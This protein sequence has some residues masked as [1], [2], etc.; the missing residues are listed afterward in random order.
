MPSTRQIDGL[1]AIHDDAYVVIRASEDWAD[2]YRQ[3]PKQFKALIRSENRQYRN[4]RQYF[5]QLANKRI[6]QWINASEYQNQIVKRGMVEAAEITVTITEQSNDYKAEETL[7]L[8]VMVDEVKE[9]MLQGVFGAREVYTRYINTAMV[10][11]MI[12]QQAVDHAAA[13]AKGLTTTTL[14]DVQRS[15]ATSINNGEDLAHAVARLQTIISNPARAELIAR[16][17]SVRSYQAGKHQYAIQTKAATK[18]WIA[19]P[20]ADEGSNE[21]PCVDDAGQAPIALGNNFISGDPYPPAHPRCR[22]DTLYNYDSSPYDDPN[23][24]YDV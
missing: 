22:C 11:E 5:K 17:E 8:G 24:I 21:T 12:A 4:L 19:L 18:E 3:A 7:I 15:V 2:S 16:T 20:G 1:K 13:L 9:G 10:N 6:A 23:Q 14:K